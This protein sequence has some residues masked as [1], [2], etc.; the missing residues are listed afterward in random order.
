M[1]HFKDKVAIVTGGAQGIG[2][3][4]AERLASDGAL[5]AILDLQQEKAEEV[6]KAIEARGGR[7]IAVKMDITNR[8]DVKKAV[9]KVE[10]T[11]D[12]V[13]I[14]VNNV[15]WD[16]AMP[17]IDCPEELWDK[18]IDINLT[19]QIAITRAVLDG[20]VSRKYGK[21]VNI[22]STAGVVGTP[23]TAEYS[24]AKAA[25]IGFTRCLAKE[26]GQYG[27]NVNCISPGPIATGTYPK[28]EEIWEKRRQTMVRPCSGAHRRGEC[29]RVHIWSSLGESH[30][31][32]DNISHERM[33]QWQR[34]YLWTG[35]SPV[36][37]LA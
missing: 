20:M 9:K 17:F 32:A 19:G 37:I 18:V 33:D 7:A 24:G 1:H 28:T 25:V 29:R 27:I 12:K 2:Q 21:I 8:D 36:L 23:R 30:E 31:H 22:A 15:G 26:V 14:L 34:I 16:K 6:A 5:V 10:E 13:D 35:E 4:I 11:F 3:G